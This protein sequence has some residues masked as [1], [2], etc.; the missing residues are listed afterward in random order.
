MKSEALRSPQDSTQC[1]YSSCREMI[2]CALAMPLSFRCQRDL[3]AIMLAAG[4][5]SRSSWSLELCTFVID[6][7]KFVQA[8]LTEHGIARKAAL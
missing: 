3:H 8:L 1:C 2:A 5:S 4:H 7:Q 6:T